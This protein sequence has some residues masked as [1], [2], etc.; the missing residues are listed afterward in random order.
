[1]AIRIK[2]VGPD[3]SER[4][5]WLIIS[6][7]GIEKTPYIIVKRDYKGIKTYWIML[8]ANPDWQPIT[9]DEYP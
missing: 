2:E 9:V 7:Y 3:G 6:N 5:Y 8:W 4:W 1:M